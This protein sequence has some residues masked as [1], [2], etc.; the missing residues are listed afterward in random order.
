MWTPGAYTGGIAG[1]AAG[2]AQGPIC[3]TLIAGTTNVSRIFVTCRLNGAPGGVPA[4]ESAIINA[5]IRH[6]VP[7]A[8]SW[9]QQTLAAAPPPTGSRAPASKTTSDGKSVQ[10]THSADDV[11]LVIEPEALARSDKSTNGTTGR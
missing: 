10:I 2:S 5:T 6:F 1:Y 11:L 9:A 7:G 4:E 8:A 3:P